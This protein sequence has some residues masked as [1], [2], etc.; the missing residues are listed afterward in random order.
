VSRLDLSPRAVTARLRAASAL[1]D[2]RPEHRLDAKLGLTAAGITAR[3]KLASELRD[4]CARL[5]QTGRR[6]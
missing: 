1:A 4:L 6:A 2:L 3:L 5:Q